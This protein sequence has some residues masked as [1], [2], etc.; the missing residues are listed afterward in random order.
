MSGCCSIAEGCEG[1]LR[2]SSE[3]EGLVT[4]QVCSRVSP[5]VRVLASY[6]EAAAVWAC[7]AGEGWGIMFAGSWEKRQ[8]YYDLLRDVVY[9]LSAFDAAKK[10]ASAIA[11][12][13]DGVYATLFEGGKVLFYNPT[14]E[15]KCVDLFGTTVDL[16]PVSL[17]H[18]FLEC[19]GEN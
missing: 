11:C 14:N 6:K 3:G 18:A 15:R 12:H 9:R 19:G 8:R 5:R 2:H 1:F 17:G 4:D 10:D 16:A 7:P 13:W